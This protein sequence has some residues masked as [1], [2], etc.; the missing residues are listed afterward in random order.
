LGSYE[1]EMVKEKNITYLGATN[2]IAMWVRTFIEK[3][4]KQEKNCIRQKLNV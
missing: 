4:H 2:D 3:K 1:L